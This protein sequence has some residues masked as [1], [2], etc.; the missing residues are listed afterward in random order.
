[1]PPE[2]IDAQTLIVQAIQAL[3]S[4]TASVRALEKAQDAAARETADHRRWEEG[5]LASVASGLDS[6]KQEL[7]R[8]EDREDAEAT[9]SMQRWSTFTGAA[10]AV[11]RSPEARLLLYAL[12]LALAAWLGVEQDL[13]HVSVGGGGTP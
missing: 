1:M 13:L 2:P 12:V 6:V 11:W 4:L 5:M 7:Q 9:L 3:D 10:G 8:R